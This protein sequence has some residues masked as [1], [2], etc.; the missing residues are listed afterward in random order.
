VTTTL[1]TTK[2]EHPDKAGAILH[3]LNSRD[4]L[5]REL[6]RRA[7]KEGEL[8][9]AAEFAEMIH[10]LARQAEHYGRRV[11]AIDFSAAAQA[12]FD[13][14]ERKVPTATIL[15]DDAANRRRIDRN[16]SPYANP[17]K[18]S[19]AVD[20]RRPVQR[21]ARDGGEREEGRGGR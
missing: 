18:P 1:D 8:V 16:R 15:I 13:D 6:R 12:L 3:L 2:L 19:L 17:P 7:G 4:D 20:P 5:V 9:T 10:G 11:G 21:P 14:A